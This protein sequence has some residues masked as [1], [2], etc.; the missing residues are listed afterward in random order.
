[1]LAKHHPGK[2]S[3]SF[4]CAVFCQVLFTLL[5]A[6]SNH[7]EGSRLNESKE[8]NSEMPGKHEQ[9]NTQRCIF[10][11]ASPP[12]SSQEKL[13][14]CTNHKFH[15]AQTMFAASLQLN[16]LRGSLLPYRVA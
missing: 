6:V 14:F 3:E 16:C 8:R 9:A 13:H 2:S 12:H 4:T 11:V 1:M 10:L 5:R 7:A 15:L